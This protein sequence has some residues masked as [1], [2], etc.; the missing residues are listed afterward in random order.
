MRFGWF[1]GSW[2]CLVVARV[3]WWL[4]SDFYDVFGGCQ[5]VSNRLGVARLFL[6]CF[7]GF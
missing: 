2:H 6:G 1:L 5:D 3:F 7:G 4:L